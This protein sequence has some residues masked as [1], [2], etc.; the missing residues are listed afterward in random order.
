MSSKTVVLGSKI[1]LSLSNAWCQSALT[2]KE[3][4]R[5]LGLEQMR[6]RTV[7][8]IMSTVNMKGPQV[9]SKAILI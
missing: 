9:E 5:R 1:H 6:Q 3:G 8:K 2:G 4:C 7:E